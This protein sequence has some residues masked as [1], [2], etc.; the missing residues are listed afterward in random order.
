[1][2]LLEQYKVCID[3]ERQAKIINDVNKE[4]LY[5]DF[6]NSQEQGFFRFMN[7]VYTVVDELK[8]KAKVSQFIEI[9]ARIKDVASALTN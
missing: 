4:N 5:V 7:Y 8:K 3:E 6:I 9:R 2:H 1:M